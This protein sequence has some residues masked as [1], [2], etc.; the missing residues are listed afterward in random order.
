MVWVPWKYSED[1]ISACKNVNVAVAAYVTIQARLKL[2][3]YL[4][5]LW[6]LCCTASAICV[7]NVD[8]PQKGHQATIW[9]TSQ[10]SFEDF[11]SGSFIG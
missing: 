11:Y 10:M 8:E 3:E 9:F 1:N 5:E 2:Y 4:S 7:E 6:S